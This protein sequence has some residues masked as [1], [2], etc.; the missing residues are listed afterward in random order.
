MV[1]TFDVALYCVRALLSTRLL[2]VE[3]KTP[4]EIGKAKRA[5]TLTLRPTSTS[6]FRCNIT[7]P[8]SKSR[9]IGTYGF[10]EHFCIKKKASWQLYSMAAFFPPVR[11]VEEQ[12]LH[13]SD[14][15]SF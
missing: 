13:S 11:A 14:F 9:L 2:E 7:Y 12:L 1:S 15:S 5:S 3:G 8:I 4:W 6:F 10:L